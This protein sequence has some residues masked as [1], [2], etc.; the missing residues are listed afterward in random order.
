[1]TDHQLGLAS[2]VSS[3][4]FIPAHAYYRQINAVAHP[5]QKITL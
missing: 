3:A 1:M 4:V 2:Q 5:W